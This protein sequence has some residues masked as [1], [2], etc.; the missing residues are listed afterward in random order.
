MSNDPQRKHNA[1]PLYITGFLLSLVCTIIPY[2][3]VVNHVLPAAILLVTIIGFALVQAVI[4]VFF[5]L[6]L[7]REKKPYWQSSFLVATVGAIF[8]V[9]VG[10]LWIMDHLHHSMTPTQVADRVSDN[11]AIYE[12][13]N[14]QTGTC[15]A[16]KGVTRKI[17]LSN[18]TIIPRHT[19]AQLCD[20]IM[21]VN[22][23][24]SVRAIMFGT[25]E[26]LGTYAG[27]AS[28]S[29]RNGRNKLIKLTESGTYQFH[30]HENP[31]IS[32]DFV[33]NR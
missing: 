19:T 13:S 22:E 17:V 9:V 14:E 24:E 33:V 18:D 7:G 29:I 5:F 25:H 27:E 31:E 32:G 11:E 16:D 2:L 6:H 1:T 15:P 4:Q 12:I 10:S 20:S 23:S 3:L 8:V 30:D 21:I 28:L 26:Q